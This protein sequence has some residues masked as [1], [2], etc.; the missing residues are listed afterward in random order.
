MTSPAGDPPHATASADVP[1]SERTLG[2]TAVLGATVFW[3]F[4]SVLG[5]AADVSGVT[6]GFWRMWIATAMMTVIVLVTKRRPGRDDLRNAAVLGVLFGFNIVAFFITLQYL[7]VAI[8]LIIG[9]LTPVVA[10]PI[11]VLFMGER[12][13]WVKGLCALAATAGVVAAVVTAAP[14]EDAANSTVGYV[15]AV[16]SLFIWVVYLLANKRVRAKVET[17]RLMW[18]L[19]FV[20]ALTVSVITLFVRPDLG[21]LQ[22]ADWLWV[23]LLS[24]GPGILGHGLLSW[25]Q[26]RVDAS[27]SSVL[28]Q[29]EPVG[30][31]IWAWVFLGE[32]LSVAQALSMMVVVVAL[33]VLAYSE[34]RENRVVVDEALG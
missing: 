11:A 16:I 27:V 9:S 6:L 20:G 10:L 2:V 31:S 33:G 28:I 4:G 14:P 29:G 17:V 19:S 12:L 5:K 3:S 8:T 34:A 13:T 21:E 18:V 7:S 23:T 22:G 30:A 32:S 25:A 24:I 15:W 26:P 1:R